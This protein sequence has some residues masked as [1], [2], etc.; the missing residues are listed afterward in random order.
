MSAN[1]LEVPI[2]AAIVTEK[3][4]NPKLV[5]LSPVPK[6]ILNEIDEETWLSGSELLTDNSSS[7]SDSDDDINEKN[8]IVNKC[9]QNRIKNMK[10]KKR[11]HFTDE[12]LK[13]KPLKKIINKPVDNKVDF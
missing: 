2:T 11:V 8:I 9:N 3:L 10:K 4:P 1:E 7:S 12:K 5:K 13:V 6:H